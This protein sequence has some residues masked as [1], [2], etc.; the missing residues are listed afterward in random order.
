M[1]AEAQSIPAGF[2]IVFVQSSETRFTGRCQGELP[3]GTRAGLAR[4][5]AF[6]DAHHIVGLDARYVGRPDERMAFVNLQLVD[7][8]VEFQIPE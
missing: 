4:Q 7:Q 1:T 5:R 3:A 2:L 6:H 8:R